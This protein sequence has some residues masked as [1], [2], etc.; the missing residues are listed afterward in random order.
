M[1]ACHTVRVYPVRLGYLAAWPLA[2]LPP[3]DGRAT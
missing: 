3:A 2:E 1:T